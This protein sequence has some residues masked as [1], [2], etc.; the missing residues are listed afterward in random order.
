MQAL[1]SAIY[2]F[3]VNY[4]IILKGDK[5]KQVKNN[6][7]KMKQQSMQL[8]SHTDELSR[9]FKIILIVVVLFAIFYAI[10]YYVTKHQ[11]DAA[12]NTV[13]VENAVIQYDEIMLGTLLTQSPSSYYVLIEND[14]DQFNQTYESYLDTYKNSG[15]DDVLRVYTADLSDGLNANYIGEENHFDFESLSDFKIKETAL[16]KVVDG[17]L[18]EHYVGSQDILNYLKSI[19]E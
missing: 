4:V 5:M 1:E 6:K 7:K 9:L 8:T 2:F 12:N 11:K 19:T 17:R 10:T 13:P 16:V 18:E 15:K 14:G 3:Y